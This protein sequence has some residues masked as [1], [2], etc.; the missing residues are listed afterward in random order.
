MTKIEQ[1][2]KNGC[3][4]C[5]LPTKDFE[6]KI[7]EVEGENELVLICKKCGCVHGENW[8]QF[9]VSTNL[10]K[11][12]EVFQQSYREVQEMVEREKHSVEPASSGISHS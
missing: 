11:E 3:L 1:A 5:F 12:K 9:S 8:Y 4:H 6:E 10:F 2:E 7:I